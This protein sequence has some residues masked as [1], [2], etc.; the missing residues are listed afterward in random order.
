MTPIKRNYDM[1]NQKLWA[2]GRNE[3][4][5]ENRAGSGLGKTH[6]ADFIPPSS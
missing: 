3:Q 1:P 4:A 2:V 6:P 5:A